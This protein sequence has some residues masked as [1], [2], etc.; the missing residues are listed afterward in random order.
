[1]EVAEQLRVQ[2][3][4]ED[5]GDQ[6]PIDVEDG[7]AV[8]HR[9]EAEDLVERHP[10]GRRDVHPIADRL[11]KV[12]E[13]VAHQLLG[14]GIG[15]DAV[16]GGPQEALERRAL[17]EDRRQPRIVSKQ[18]GRRVLGEVVELGWVHRE[19]VDDLELGSDLLEP[20]AGPERDLDVMDLLGLEEGI[21]DLLRGHGLPE[22]EVSGRQ[23]LGEPLIAGEE[24][25]RAAI[26]QESLLLEPGGDVRCRF[27][28]ADDE[29]DLGHVGR[30]G[31]GEL[32]AEVL[33]HEVLHERHPERSRI[34]GGPAHHGVPDQRAEG[35]HEE[36]DH[37]PA[38][39]QGEDQE[40]QD[41]GDAP[42]PA[43]V[44]A[45]VSA[46]AAAPP[47]AAT[48]AAPA[49]LAIGQVL[50]LPGIVV[51]AR[52]GGTGLGALACAPPGADRHGRASESGV[53]GRARA[54]SSSWR[55]IA[56][57]SRSTRAL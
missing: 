48:T 21:D 40:L 9:G 51:R 46:V 8:D 13:H 3:V 42:T 44:P 10:A 55:M 26:G 30:G 5:T 20:E 38:E 17:R 33:L 47:P 41:A 16:R 4:L 25:E 2:A 6:R 23:L 1:M 27:A 35:R 22:D 18:L 29:C 39:D 34:V 7:L 15:Q 49:A 31:L 28:R 54:S 32:V 19:P 45:V 53:G 52:V 37:D 24:D 36:D 11:V 57:A 56:A 14:R 12:V 43:V 50:R